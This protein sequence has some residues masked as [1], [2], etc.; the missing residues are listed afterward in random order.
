MSDRYV[1]EALLRPAVEFNSAI[2]AAGAAYVCIV[3]PWAVALAPSI[4]YVTA[5][6]FACFAIIRARQGWRVLRYRRNLRRLPL[7]IMSSNQIPIS[8]QRLFLGKGFLW[9]QK[10]TQRLLETQR[11]EVENY[12]KPPMYYQLARNFEQRFEF[13]FPRF[14]RLLQSDNLFNPVRPL[15]PVGGNPVLHGIE[16]DETNV[17]MDLRERVGHALVLGTTRVGKTRLAELLITQDIRRG[18]ITIVFDPKGDADLLKRIWA[19]AHRAGRSE[20]L[21]IFHLG[22]PDISARYNAVGRF[23]RVSEV[24]TRIA[25]QLSGEGNSAAFRAFAW[26]F[27]NIVAR[28]LV[29]LGQRP[30]YGLILRYVTNIGELYQTYSLKIIE[31]RLPV[32]FTQIENAQNVLTEN[33]VPRHMQNDPNAALLSPDY[34]DMNDPRPMFDWQQVIRK[35]GI[36]YIG[37]D[38]L[39]DAEVAAAVGNSMFADLVSYA[40]HI[41]KFGVHDGLHEGDKIKKLPISLHCDEFN[42]L[43]G[44]EFIPLL[45]KSGGAGIEVTA[46]TQTWS[47]IEARLGNA[48]KSAQVTGNFNTLIMLR[49]REL[50]TAKLLTEQLPEIDVYT[51]TLV[52]GI[53]DISNPGQGSDFTSNTQDRVSMVAKPLLSPSDVI[54]LPKGQ[55][56]AL[57]EGGKLWKIRM[58]LP[59]GKDDVLMPE[60]LKKIEEYMRKN[61]RTGDSW[62]SASQIPSD[63]QEM[64]I[65]LSEEGEDNGSASADKS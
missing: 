32:L 44:D 34:D 56:F 11:P 57:L 18:N 51:K 42:E 17:S 25:G 63:V 23:G 24:A 50:A 2:A 38:A 12:I 1:I 33:D 58:P 52:S 9:L 28:A 13:R 14:C 48:A 35:Q 31:E 21:Y 6:A 27:V 37:L 54:Q 19:E 45:N 36:V 41:Y 30:D 65:Q 26:R 40:G 62:W 16:P 8:N 3:A 47:D 49:V 43:M 39:S 61:Y 60:N 46:Y 22:W 20:E 64:T 4:S 53:T 15:P 59:D 10:H 55:A 7:Y 5:G 29:A